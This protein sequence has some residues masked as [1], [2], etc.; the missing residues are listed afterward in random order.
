MNVLED[1]IFFGSNENNQVEFNEKD[2]IEFNEKDEIEFSDEDNKTESNNEDKTKSNKK[3]EELFET[4]KRYSKCSSEIAWLSEFAVTV[5]I[6][7]VP[8]DSKW[9]IVEVV[10]KHNYSKTKN[11]RVFYEHRQ[12]IQE[13]KHTAMQI[14][15]ANAKPSTI[16]KAIRDENGEPTVTKRNIL[17]LSLQ[18]YILE[19]N[20]SIEALI[21]GMKKEDIQFDMKLKKN[22]SNDLI[23]NISSIKFD[24][25]SLKFQLYKI[26]TQ[27]INFLDKQQK[28]VLL[29]K[30]DN[31]LVVLET[32][33]SEIKILKKI[34]GKECSSGTK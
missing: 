13:A 24:N 11:V 4:K 9:K 28:S 2:E 31:I 34:T 10:N 12:L 29:K 19:E 8:R 26:E 15:K 14:L 1:L 7:V 3:N 33:L 32:K 18:I 21:I 5:K 25:F 23:E 30:L 22:N 6:K 17:N 27:Y 20:S 16:C